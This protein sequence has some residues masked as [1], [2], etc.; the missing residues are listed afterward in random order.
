MKLTTSIGCLL[1][2]G[3]LAGCS[4]GSGTG[5]TFAPLH[6]TQYKTVYAPM[7]TR[8][9]EVYRREIEMRITEAVQKRIEG[10]T[11]YRLADKAHADTALTGS[12]DQVVQRP[13]SI[14]PNTNRPREMAVTFIVSFKWVDLATGRTIVERSNFRVEATYYPIDPLNEDFFQGSEDAANRLAERVVEQM[15]TPM[16]K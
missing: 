4:G 14:N 8:G 16:T 2:L 12:L 13:L 6:P 3:A 10:F 15:E 7:W 1:L 5:Y 11:P 9:K